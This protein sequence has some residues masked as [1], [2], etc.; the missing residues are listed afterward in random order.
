MED[1]TN[2]G[3]Y[4]TVHAYT[5]RVVRE[6]VE[7]GVKCIEHGML[8]DDKTA[9]R[10]ADKG[11]C[12]SLQPFVPE[13]SSPMQSPANRE[14]QLRVEAG[15]ENAYCLGKKYGMQVAF[16]TGFS[17]ARRTRACRARCLPICS[18]GSVLPRYW[19]WPRRRMRSCAPCPESAVPKGGGRF[20]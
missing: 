12:W 1:A 9:K 4:V 2:W 8:I 11:A 14:K 3:T 15:T 16:G 10:S 18:T 17:S 7:A 19:R 13:F 5:S 6:A 20:A